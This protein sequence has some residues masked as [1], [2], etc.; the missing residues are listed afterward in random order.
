M[1]LSVLADNNLNDPKLTAENDTLSD[2]LYLNV[3]DKYKVTCKGDTEDIKW[4]GPPHG[5]NIMEYSE[6]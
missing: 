6:E 2:P 1:C 4:Y 3:N 5:W